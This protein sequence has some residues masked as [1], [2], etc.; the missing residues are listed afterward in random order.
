MIKS[1][2]YIAKNVYCT[3][4]RGRKKNPDGMWYDKEGQFFSWRRHKELM[5]EIV[6]REI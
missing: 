2:N 3:V 1:S 6:Y 4:Y 5:T